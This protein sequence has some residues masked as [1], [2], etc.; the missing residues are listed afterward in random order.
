MHY[1]WSSLRWWA[2]Y[3]QSCS[4]IQ[5]DQENAVRRSSRKWSTG[6]GSRGNRPHNKWYNLERRAYPASAFISTSNTQ[7]SLC[8]VQLFERCWCSPKKRMS[9]PM[10]WWDYWA[11]IRYWREWHVFMPY[12]CVFWLS[13]ILHSTSWLLLH[14]FVMCSLTQFF[15]GSSSSNV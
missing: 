3:K 12:L 1:L 2:K 9:H 4:T 8:R 11:T 15:E 10:H 6:L 14:Y 7:V 5:R 13:P